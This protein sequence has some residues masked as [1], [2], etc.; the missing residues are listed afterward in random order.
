M[1]NHEDFIRSY[2]KLQYLS[3]VPE[4]RL[5]LNKE[6][7][8]HNIL[9]QELGSGTPR[10]YWSQSWAGGLALSRY[11][12]DNPHIVENK[13]VIDFCSGS[14]IVGIAAYMAGAKRVTCADTDPLALCSSLLNARANK[15]IIDV[16]EKLIDGD[17][18]LA[19]DPEVQSY[20]FDILRTK[21][22][23]IGCPTRNKIYL[24][25]F[26]I[27]ASYVINTAESRNDITYIL[28]S[29]C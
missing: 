16:S 27:V 8:L 11:V 24:E 21:S 19:G 1:L 20:I 5:F 6:K 12:I 3:F 2:T 22:S 4:I 25:G 23:Y 9:K 10:P 17:I 18:V 15:V 28:N 26:D 29:N 13:H 14:G 7:T